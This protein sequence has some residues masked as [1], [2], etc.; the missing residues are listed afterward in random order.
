M[1][2]PRRKRTFE[3]RGVSVRRAGGTK[4]G[5]GGDGAAS[6]AVMREPRD[7]VRASRWTSTTR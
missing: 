1:R 2:A 6:P 4:E 7:C 3:P 5:F